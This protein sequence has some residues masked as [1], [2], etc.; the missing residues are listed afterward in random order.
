[1]VVESL[2]IGIFSL[3]QIRSLVQYNQ[4]I[5]DIEKDVITEFYPRLDPVHT[6]AALEI[7]SE[8]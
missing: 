4:F 6:K 5:A 8:Y 1:M 2:Q 7:D 3:I